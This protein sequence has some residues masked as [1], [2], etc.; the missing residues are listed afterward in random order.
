MSAQWLFSKY[1][2]NNQNPLSDIWNKLIGV[3]ESQQKNMIYPPLLLRDPCNLLLQ[4][5]LLLPVLDSG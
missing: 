2:T 5:V 1:P 3:N 4:L